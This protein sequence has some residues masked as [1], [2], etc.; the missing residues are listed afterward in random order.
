MKLKTLL[1]L[2]PLWGST[3]S[4][5]FVCTVCED[6]QPIG[7]SNGI[8]VTPQGQKASC[9]DL[10]LS[11]VHLPPS[12]CKSLQA[13]AGA[14]CMCPGFDTTDST[15]SANTEDTI[16]TEH[17]E[18]SICKDG[19]MGNPG[20]L[21]LNA[22][23]QPTTCGALHES[24]AS[25]TE[26]ACARVQ[27]FAQVPCGCA[28]ASELSTN[29]TGPY[30]CSI[31]GEGFV[32]NPYGI[33]VNSRGQQRTCASLNANRTAIPMSACSTMQ[34]LAKVPC[35]CTIPSIGLNQTLYMNITNSSDVG[36]I[37]GLLSSVCSIC[38]GGEIMNPDGVI[39]TPQ[40][41]STKCDILYANAYTIPADACARVQELAMEPCGCT[42]PASIQPASGVDSI[43]TN[44]TSE[45]ASFV[46]SVCGAGEM[47]ILDGIVTSR[48]GQ[49]AQ[50]S[51]LQANALSIPETACPSLQALASVP[52]GCTQ[53][54]TVIAVNST[55]GGLGSAAENNATC[56]VCVGEG[57]KI[58]IPG[59]MIITSLGMFT[60]AG[61]YS[62]G[63]TGAIPMDHCPSIQI[64]VMEECGC[65]ADG[66]TPAPS[67]APY[68]CSIC[69]DGRMVTRPG[70]IVDVSSS[71]I[72][73]K[74]LTCNQIE[75][76]AIQGGLEDEQC[77]ILQQLSDFPCGCMIPPSATTAAP[78]SF[79]CSI[80][81]E[82]MVIGYPDG[83][84]VLP[85]QQRMSC[86]DV[87]QRADSGIIQEA[88][89]IQIQP[90]VRDSCE[91][92]EEDSVPTPPTAS[93]TAYECQICGD[94]LKVTN[95]DGV[96]IIPTQ[97]D[98]T[99]AV[100]LEAAAIGNINPSQ[101]HLLHPFVLGPCGCVD[102]F[103]DAP[104]DVPSFSPTAPSI[105][106]APTGISVRDD[107]FSDLGDIYVLESAVEDV[108][109]KR[110]YVLCPGRTFKMGVWTEE[111]EIKD[112]EPFLALRPN[113]I[114][115]CGEDGSRLN[116]CVLEGGDFG[117]ASYYG[118][119]DGIYETVAGVEIRG[120]TFESQ[121]LFSV[122]LKAAG[123][124]TFI[125]CAFKVRNN[126]YY[127]KPIYE[128]LQSIPCF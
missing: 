74:N 44:S 41:R 20:G 81:G 18:C 104:S 5:E 22:A 95:P 60:C 103:S 77:T 32:G 51:V 40:G 12:A 72:G 37:D 39:T 25:I 19:E 76:L 70:G 10:S 89:C 73:Q 63:L 50:C 16:R 62:A 31:C 86:A 118:V 91:C 61:M 66:P 54:E 67:E 30:E 75:S 121:N 100:L 97:P 45:L 35:E 82:G 53:H 9:S 113:V 3:T 42:Q 114:Y 79:M 88:Q 123:D 52:C 24:R 107:C 92:I 7:D 125:G 87:Q 99:C 71:L 27:A 94:G 69:S 1:L 122:L 78:S 2:A 106:P 96:V 55:E 11:V 57:R 59:K 48:Q 93:P 47:T 83:E 15:A 38:A 110:K 28:V 120:L 43:G 112:G 36:L 116:R 17:F 6:G 58:G 64:S 84:V 26:S 23:G 108:S 98:R 85:N 124:I 46:C 119:L 33:V 127:I 56:H 115:Q 8:V 90:F 101:C 68:F 4:Q 21:A 49:T 117:L 102:E 105:S 34:A 29:F 80:C 13:I 128:P 111:G 65:F 109:V 126:K 14:P